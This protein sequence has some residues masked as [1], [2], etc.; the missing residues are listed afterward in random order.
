M[1]GAS[2]I[3]EMRALRRAMPGRVGLVPTM[4]YLHEGHLSLVRAARERD[5]HVVASIFVNPTQFGP[6]EDYER[7]PRDEERDLSLLRDER[8]D[9]VFIPSVEEMYPEDASTFVTVEGITDVLEGVHRP[10][11]FRGVATVVTQ[12]FTVVEPH[13]AYF[14]QKDAQQL[15]V[16]RR[17]VRD[18]HLDVEIVPMPTVREPDGLAM[19]SRNAYLSG[20][21]RGAA[22]VLS[23]A[24]QRAGELFAA[25]E[26]DGDR[27]RAAMRDLIAR[28]PLARVD[29]VSVAD[30]ETLRELGRVDG[31]ALVSLAVR[32]GAVRLID[33]VT[34]PPEAPD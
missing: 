14:G 26:R 10:G 1:R 34:L 2:T 18:L 22:L 13:R 16:V 21:E 17:L 30:T 23:R 31:D 28:E 32:I 29:Y 24:L 25:G 9:A 11:H 6:G 15:A 12:L 27:L 19:S 4:G 3:E 8:V 5:D 33:N 20:L 7:Y